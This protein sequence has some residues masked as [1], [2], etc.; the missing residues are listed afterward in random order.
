MFETEAR[1]VV[2]NG[3]T[4]KAAAGEAILTVEQSRV[5]G[6]ARRFGSHD[7]SIL[8][9]VDTHPG[10]FRKSG[11]QKTCGRVSLYEWQVRDLE[12]CK[13]AEKQGRRGEG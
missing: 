7:G 12:G 2:G 3:Q 10:C 9:R 4:A 1:V 8:G 13:E 11:K 6:D 5:G